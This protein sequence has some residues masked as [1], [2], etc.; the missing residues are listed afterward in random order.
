MAEF[1]ALAPGHIVRAQWPGPTRFQNLPNAPWTDQQG[2]AEGW[3]T[4]YRGIGGTANWFH[5]GITN[6]TIVEGVRLTCNLAAVT[7]N[8]RSG[9]LL[10]NFYLW[11]RTDNFFAR[12]GLSVGGD[13]SNS[14]VS[15]QNAFAVNKQVQGAIGISVRVTFSSDANV[16]FT[17]AGLRFTN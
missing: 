15:N 5:F 16:T 12:D 9:A 6:P 17:G 8:L 7:L 11:D 1:F 4:T 14:W 3:G 13:L 10:S 2:F